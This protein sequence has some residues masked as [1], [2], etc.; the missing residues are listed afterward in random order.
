M[1]DLRVI[2]PSRPLGVNPLL[3]RYGY[4]GSEVQVNRP[5]ASGEIPTPV[6]PRGE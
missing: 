1:K 2:I 5:E 3:G 4:M 6:P